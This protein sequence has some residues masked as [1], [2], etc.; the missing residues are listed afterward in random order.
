MIFFRSI[1]WKNFLSTGQHW[2][3]VDL[4]S[5]KSTLIVGENGAGK[6]TLLDA[7]SFVLYSKPFRKINKPQLLNS[8]NKKD[9]Q[10]EVVFNIGSDVF[11]VV[12]GLKPVLFEIW[13]NDEMLNQDAAARDYQGYLEQNILKMNFK[14]FGQIVVLGSST[15][16]PFMQLSAANRR[17]VIEDLLDIQVFSTMS[18]LLKEKV[19]ENK[20]A[21]TE[22][23]H[24]FALSE[25]KLD[26]ARSHNEE[27]RQMRSI[28]VDRIKVRVKQQLSLIEQSQTELDSCV[29]DVDALMSGVSDKGAEKAKKEEYKKIRF[30]L[31]SK[32]K[33]LEKET[34]FYENHDDCPTCKQGIEENFKGD[35]VRANVAKVKE[36]ESALEKLK[37]KEA[38]VEERLLEISD[39]EDEISAK[40]LQAGEH[41]ANIRMAKNILAGIKEDLKTAEQA[42]EEISNESIE[43][44]VGSL[45]ALDKT[46]SALSFHKETLSVATS[47]LKDGGIKT[48]IIKQYVPVINKLINK[49][50]SSLEFFVDFNLDE[51]FNETIRSRFRDEFSYASFSEGEKARIDLSLIL[52][53]RAIARMRN[54][55]STN[56]LIL[57]EVFDGSLDAQGTEE[58]IKIF[59]NI[60]SDSNIFV[61]SH[62]SDV[63]ADK[64]DRTINFIKE[65]GFS[66]IAS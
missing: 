4:S 59:N 23:K 48:R 65:R 7:I 17:E 58:L 13:K 33:L 3:E 26:S 10:V 44:L 43:K 64:F 28:E 18:N 8:V 46:L 51:T 41:R 1:K 45:K 29:D 34:D 66:R 61:I 60:V 56:L 53:W 32:R 21:V 20:T 36:I 25:Q 22:A 30:S 49:Y 6:S 11:R 50:L 54:S 62:K 27:I 47:I 24:N 40:N 39:I 52:T 2:T 12:R 37:E 55:V 63:M 14:S 19:Q 16:V 35:S 38:L 9:L 42:V 57:D 5:H 31:E 15:F